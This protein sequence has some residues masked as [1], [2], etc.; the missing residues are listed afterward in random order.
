MRDL[1]TSFSFLDNC[2]PEEIKFLTICIS[3][4]YAFVTDEILHKYKISINNM[5]ENS[6]LHPH[7]YKAVLKILTFLNNSLQRE[8]N[9]DLIRK[10]C[11]LIKRK[12]SEMNASE[13]C[14]LFEVSNNLPNS[15]FVEL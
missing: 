1:Y 4:A 10:C 3:T 12:I 5:I 13:V 6:S 14:I 8:R 11:V 15:F 9:I 2:K 7:D